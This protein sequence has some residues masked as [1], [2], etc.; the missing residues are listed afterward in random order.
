MLMINT[1]EKTANHMNIVHTANSTTII[2][3]EMTI[4]V[5][6]IQHDEPDIMQI[7]YNYYQNHIQYNKKSIKNLL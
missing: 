1:I 7:E 4:N 3:I 5:N 6:I 2:C